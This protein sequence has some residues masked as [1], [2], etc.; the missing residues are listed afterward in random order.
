MGREGGAEFVTRMKRLDSQAVLRGLKDFQRKT[1]DYVFHRL[2]DDEP[3]AKRFLI[4]DE[5]GLGKT[6]VARGLI[7]RTIDLLTAKNV[8]RIDVIYICSNADIARQNINRLNV[9]GGQD[10]EIASRIT[11]LPIF[12]KDL[13]HNRI[14]FVSFT[15]GTSFDLRSGLG[16][17]V[18][19]ALLY[20]LLQKAWRLRGSGSLNVLQGQSQTENFRKLIKSFNRRHD[21]DQSL[22]EDFAKALEQHIDKEKK[23]G[24]LDLKARFDDLCSRFGRTRIRRRIPRV[25]LQDQV[26]M[27]GE[28]RALLASTCLMALEPDLIILDEFQRFKHL[29]D[30]TDKAS[31]LARDLFE[32]E[33]ARVLLLSATPYKMY[34]LSHESGTDDH[35]KDFIRTIKFLQAD[36]NETERFERLLQDYRKELL[37]FSGDDETQLSRIKEELESKLRQVMVRTE[38]LAS[39][40]NREG[41]LRQVQSTTI[42]LSP[43]DLGDYLS[44]QKIARLLNQTDTLEYWK[45]APYLLN[46]MEGYKLKDTFNKSA[47]VPEREKQLA[48]ILEGAGLLLNWKDVRSYKQ[49]DPGNARMRALLDDTVGK[50]AWRL[51]WMPP[52]LSYYELGFPFSTP[53]LAQFTKRLVF[54]SWRVAPRVIASLLSYEAERLAIR[55]FEKRASNTAEARKRRKGL[56]RFARTEDR[57]SGMPVLGL[58]YPCVTLARECDPVKLL[59]RDEQLSDALALMKTRIE[60][61]LTEI[62]PSQTDRPE[63]EAWYWAAP[64]LL[65]LRFDRKLSRQWLTE[66]RPDDIWSTAQDADDGDDGSLWAE[67]VA[68]ARKLALG[69]SQLGAPPSDLSQVLALMALGSPSVTALRSLTRIRGSQG[70]TISGEIRSHAVTVAWAFRRLFNAPESMGIVRSMPGPARDQPYWRRVLEYSA[71]GCL[72]ATMDE[73]AHILRESL[74]LLDMA[75]ET[76]CQRIAETMSE[77]LSLR[78]PSIGADR[79]STDSGK[80][81]IENERLRVHF[82]VRFGDEKTDDL[83]EVSRAAQVRESFNSPFWPFVLATTSVGQEGLDFHHYC[84]AVVH[85]NLPSNPVDLEQREG[86]V[87]RYKGHAVRKNLAKSLGAGAALA[88]GSDP[89]EEIFEIARGQRVDGSDI[90]PYWVYQTEGGAYIERHVPALPMSIESEHLE[91][92]KRSL[93]VYRMVFGQSSQEDLIKYLLDHFPE[94]EI[95]RITEDLRIRLEPT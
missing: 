11:L 22:A 79:I 94:S 14:N 84:H 50:G 23:R 82:A 39:S 16:K 57:L 78:R 34:T 41:M 58:L 19:R 81:N 74:G 75:A 21:I 61:L 76:S 77:A 60:E 9:T 52:S 30:G 83:K 95:K 54:S 69:R 42:R 5:V 18:E 44:L 62:V 89:W 64:I 8:Q 3:K 53:G 67:H 51:L 25:D 32:F 24:E 91:D 43:K 92:L 59:S 37:R 2:Y 12:L 29:L 17:D 46:F 20:W 40:D 1:V 6:L 55:S 73:Y 65:D 93:V 36:P 85:W 71:N 88:D 45:T 56:L 68:E 7:A 80:L 13:K 72:Q 33:E 10:F 48:K 28:L 35:Y 4:A 27:V 90:V 87:H 70:K 15:P 86:R 38:K 26:R 49:I 66:D 47:E 31:E 63:D